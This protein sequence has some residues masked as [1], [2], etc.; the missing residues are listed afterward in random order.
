M[1]K[2]N[3]DSRTSQTGTN[4]F[5][6]TASY[7][8]IQPEAN[9]YINAFENYRPE[10][11]PNIGF[12]AAAERN[13]LNRSFINPTGGY[14][15][16]QMRDKMMNSANRDIDQQSAIEGRQ[17]T[18]DVNQQRMGQLGSLAALM[19]PRLVQTGSSGTGTSNMTGQSHTSTGQNAWG[20]ILDIGLGAATAFG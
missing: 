2:Q 9:R 6:N 20:N 5:S 11:D 16:P 3:T 12:R 14:Y 18:Y 19:A 4:T 15:T 8:Q 13:R 17:G 7:G 1:P 10:M